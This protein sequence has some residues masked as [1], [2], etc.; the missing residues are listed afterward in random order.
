MQKQGLRELLVRAVLDDGFRD[1]VLADPDAAAAA[2]DLSEAEMAALRQG[3]AAGPGLAGS[4]PDAGSAG[5]GEDRT[6][7]Q[8]PPPLTVRLLL[9]VMQ[10]ID[11]VAGEQGRLH[12]SAALQPM[13]AETDAAEMPAPEVDAVVLPG[14]RLKDMLL[15]IRV[16]PHIARGAGGGL[17]ASFRHAVLPVAG[18]APLRPGAG[19]A[20]PSGLDERAEAVRQA[21]PAERYAALLDLVGA[22]G[23]AAG[24]G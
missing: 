6:E 13:A 10:S 22:L 19:A 9:R 23:E 11:E 21:L 5:S 8:A 12:F 2:F 16:M 18:G 1:R 17:E 15:D 7:P 14:E 4:A 20:A 3:R 24:D